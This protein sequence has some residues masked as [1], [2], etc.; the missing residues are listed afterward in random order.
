[1]ATITYGHYGIKE[2]LEELASTALD[3]EKSALREST[4]NANAPEW[5]K[6]MQ[7]QLMRRIDCIEKHMDETQAK[8]VELLKENRRDEV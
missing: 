8:I 3:A 6:T 7:D 2:P 1:M 4:L 5:A